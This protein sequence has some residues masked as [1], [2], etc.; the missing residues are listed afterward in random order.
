MNEAFTN[1]QI[2]KEDIQNKIEQK[3]LII[4][5]E[6]G[7][8]KTTVSDIAAAAGISVGNVYNYFFTKEKLFLKLMPKVLIKKIK[9]ILKDKFTN[10]G[11]STFG[12]SR[13]LISVIIEYKYQVIIMMEK[14]AGTVYEFEKR[15]LI[16]HLITLFLEYLKK[17]FNIQEV[18]KL[19]VLLLQKIYRNLISGIVNILIITDN[20]DEIDD[21]LKKLL[22]Y[23][24]SGIH[25]YIDLL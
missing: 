10:F 12:F 13:T 16:N 9:N 22:S 5:A 20:S 18:S 14:C 11:I 7:Y 8:H 19:D 23:H 21:L 4:F 17:R 2:L 24:L 3:A 25:S 15:E 6:K 1:M